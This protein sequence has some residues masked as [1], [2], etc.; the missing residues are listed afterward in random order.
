MVLPVIILLDV[1]KILIEISVCVAIKIVLYMPLFIPD[2]ELI[3]CEKVVVLLRVKLLF[4]SA[5]K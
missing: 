4:V 2:I 3:F 5:V 1:S